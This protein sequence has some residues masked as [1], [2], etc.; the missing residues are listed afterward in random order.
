M[1]ANGESKVVRG[2]ISEWDNSTG[3]GVLKLP[4]STTVMGSNK[5]F[6]A[7]TSVTQKDRARL[8][9]GAEVEFNVKRR[10]GDL[11]VGAVNARL[12]MVPRATVG[13]SSYVFFQQVEG[14][15]KLT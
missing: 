2:S 7:R 4:G 10:T 8:A 11:S 12:V 5:V 1:E 9:C 3:T 13:P 6:L 14:S 15:K